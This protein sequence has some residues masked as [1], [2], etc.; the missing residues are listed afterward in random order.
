MEKDRVDCEGTWV[1]HVV[2]RSEEWA[3]ANQLSAGN[4]ACGA[5]WPFGPFTYLCGHGGFGGGFGDALGRSKPA[6]EKD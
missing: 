3:A 1:R 2:D 6:A 5:P 4:V